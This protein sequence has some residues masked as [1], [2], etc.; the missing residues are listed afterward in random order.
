MGKY[1]L[2]IEDI[3]WTYVDKDEKQLG[4]ILGSSSNEADKTTGM[5]GCNIASNEGNNFADINMTFQAYTFSLTNT[6]T[7]NPFGKNYVYMNNLNE[8]TRMGIDLFTNVIAQGYNHHVLTNFT[9][10]CFSK[11]VK[12]K[13]HTDFNDDANNSK[14]G[15]QSYNESNTSN[16]NIDVKLLSKTLDIPSNKFL[17]QNEGNCSIKVRYNIGKEYDKK[18]NPVQVKFES[19]DAN[20]SYLEE[21][22]PKVSDINR[23]NDINSTSIINNQ[24]QIFYFARV[25]S[26]LENYPAT[27]KKSI[28]TP[29]FVELFC[30]TKTEHQTWCRDTMNIKSI[31]KRIGQK[32]YEGWYLAHQHNSSTEGT[33]HALISQND[34]ISVNPTTNI[35]PFIEGKINDIETFYN[36]DGDLSQS[37]EAQIVIDTDVWLRFNKESILGMPKGTSS[38]TIKMK[39]ISST[40]GAG[41]TGN[42]VESVKK[43]EHNG[44]ISW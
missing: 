32:T 40:T 17:D 7:R 34:D 18:T 36:K 43:V 26:Y 8:D 35:P 22:K 21:S 29:L 20:S 19:F 6:E 5:F 33:V 27:N 12:I 28:N 25:S 14:Y 44:K 11:D 24:S 42:L 4:C 1:T 13:L 23:I 30:L 9:T 38:Y 3:N 2:H 41:N 31:G 16:T 37:I 39:S 10:G 15:I